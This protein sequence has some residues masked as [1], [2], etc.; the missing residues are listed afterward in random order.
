VALKGRRRAPPGGADTVSARAAARWP[1]AGG[2]PRR[3]HAARAAHRVQ[4]GGARE[5]GRRLAARVAA[6]AGGTVGLFVSSPIVPV[7]PCVCLSCRQTCRW[8]RLSVY[9][10]A[11][12]FL[13]Q[14]VIPSSHLS[15][16]P[17]HALSVCLCVL[18]PICHH[19]RS[20]LILALGLGRHQFVS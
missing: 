7:G 3:R 17:A 2:A 12:V 20:C 9:L 11:A 1:A 10:I 4:P 18:A 6:R 19:V 5:G 14:P 15:C 13:G 16:C 8:D